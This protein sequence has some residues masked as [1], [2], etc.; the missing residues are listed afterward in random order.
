MESGFLLYLEDP[1]WTPRGSNFLKNIQF[2]EKSWLSSW[3][4]T[5]YRRSRI[6]PSCEE[7]NLHL[8]NG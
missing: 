6:H 5:S 3:Q 1:H 8:V 4:A 2:L 7:L